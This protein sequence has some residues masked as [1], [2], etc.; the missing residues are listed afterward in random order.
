MVCGRVKGL[1]T[2]KAPSLSPT[3]TILSH[4]AARKHKPNWCWNENQFCRFAIR[5]FRSLP[6]FL[7][8]G[9]A[10]KLLSS[11]SRVV[12]ALQI[13]TF[14]SKIMVWSIGNVRNRLTECLKLIHMASAHTSSLQRPPPIPSHTLPSLPPASLITLYEVSRRTFKPPSDRMRLYDEQG[15][16]IS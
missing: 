6:R 14:Q 1:I 11:S 12:E 8:A 15:G 9:E 2:R 7:K 13:G 3:F 10:A 5:R 16:D 4:F